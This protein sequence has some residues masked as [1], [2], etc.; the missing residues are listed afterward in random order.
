MTNFVRR[1]LFGFVLVAAVGLGS[2][3]PYDRPALRVG[4]HLWPGYEPLRLAEMLG[5]Y[6]SERIKL[7]ELPS[8]EE[9][10]QEYRNG[11]IDAIAITGDEALRVAAVEPEEH[12]IIL[13]LDY[14]NGA[15]VIMARPGI[16]D[17]Q[18]LK[19]R[20]VGFQPDAVGAVMLTRALE[21]AGLSLSDIE[22]RPLPVVEHV[23][24]YQ[25]G[26]VDVV[27]T[28]EPR[29]T[30]LLKLGAHEIFSSARM[31]SEI[32]DVLLTRVSLFETHEAAFQELVGGWW[33]A[34]EHWRKQPDDAARRLAVHQSMTPAEFLGAIKGLELLDRQAN[35]QAF[36]GGAGA[37]R[38]NLERMADIMVSRGLL[39]A[40]KKVDV[41]GL[42]DDRWVSDAP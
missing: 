29:R 20:K 33:R 1:F 40:T 18:A 34:I 14:S 11:V 32:V 36:G 28:F 37:L 16:A 8:A 26:V 15:D 3:M 38:G 13:A 17:L 2:C 7:V 19:G 24:A 21:Q 41:E 4:I 6:H 22:P 5:Y 27:V 31:P 23:R 42:L 30:E 25:R 35:L 9:A 10:I 39:P 12:R